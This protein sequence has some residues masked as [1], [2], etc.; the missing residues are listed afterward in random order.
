MDLRIVGLALAIVLFT[1]CSG[2]TAAGAPSSLSVGPPQPT[3]TGSWTD[4][5]AAAK[6]E[7]LV[8]VSGQAAP[9]ADVAFAA[10][11]NK[12]YPEIQVEYLAMT[13]PEATT[14]LMTERQAGK[15]TEDLFIHGTPDILSTLLP[16][17]AVDPMEPFLVGPDARD[18]SKW[19][20]G[21]YNFA[22]DAAQYDLIFT[23]GVKVPLIYNPKLVSPSELTS[24][25]NLLDPKWKGK[26]AMF[27]PLVA[28]SGNGMAT[29]WYRTPALGKD[30]IKQ[31]FGQQL[32][33]SKDD[34]QLTDWVGQGR[35]PIAIG[36]S[37]FT[38][39][40]L[41]N[42]GVAIE[43]LPAET[44]RE[45]S[46]LT[47]SFG[48]V[49]VLNHA[50]HPNASRVYLNWLLSKTVQEELV[51]LTSYPSRRLD[52]VATGLPQ[53]VVPKPG[54][55]YQDGASEATARLKNEVVDYLKSVMSG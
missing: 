39:N 6:R 55:I 17:G 25:K 20:G 27:D 52:A 28:G 30:F 7:G 1:G 37:D 13:S 44:L 31:L 36:A 33:I 49:A 10:G 24:Y 11:F 4:V 38:A 40:D 32:D 16:A 22:D 45:T 2:S 15:F 21:K 12:Q 48:S 50:P 8:V 53:S 54:V 18:P 35:N 43:L 9:G 51:K 46:Y 34:R 29:F 23:G 19:L 5:V 41:K 26:L 14:K 47:A 3:V 42:K